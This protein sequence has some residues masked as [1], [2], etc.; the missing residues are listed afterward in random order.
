MA[1]RAGDQTTTVE[2]DRAA[3]KRVRD[4]DARPVRPTSKAGRERQREEFGGISLL[5]TLVGWLA[6]AGLVAILTG[7]L[8]AAGA[9]LALSTTSSTP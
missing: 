1:Y 6:T 4:D 5:C 9:A 3:V 8:S 2:H 7:M